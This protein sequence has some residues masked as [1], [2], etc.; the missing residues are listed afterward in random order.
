MTTPPILSD[1]EIEA[2]IASVARSLSVPL[3]Q[4]DIA[5]IAENVRRWLKTYMFSE[6]SLSD[7][8]GSWVRGCAP[9]VD[10]DGQPIGV[11]T[12]LLVPFSKGGAGN[13][14]YMRRMVVV[15][16]LMPEHRGYGYFT[17]TLVLRRADD[18]KKMRHHYASNCLLLAP[19]PAAS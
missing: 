17:R 9:T 4:A 16:I 19:A 14:A 10:M 1:T 5:W 12:T 2:R 6:N 3:T 8:I 15:E 13:A 7:A 11:G 18:G